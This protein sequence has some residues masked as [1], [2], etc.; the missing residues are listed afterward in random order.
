MP[1]LSSFL[2]GPGQLFGLPRPAGLGVSAPSS[3]AA[4]TTVTSSHLDA[5]LFGLGRP[6]MSLA[7][8]MIGHRPGHLVSPPRPDMDVRTLLAK[9]AQLDHAFAI[10]VSVLFIYLFDIT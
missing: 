6:R 9:R 5:G 3:T 4:T 10:H 2:P 1:P 8:G 7:P